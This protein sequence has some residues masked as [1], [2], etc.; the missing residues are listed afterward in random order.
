MPV[1]ASQIRAVLSS[2]PVANCLPS[3]QSHRAILGLGPGDR[4]SE[5]WLKN[6]PPN[7]FK[8]FHHILQDMED[9]IG[10]QRRSLRTWVK[11]QDAFKGSSIEEQENA[12]RAIQNEINGHRDVQIGGLFPIEAMAMVAEHR[13]IVRPPP[14]GGVTRESLAEGSPEGQRFEA[15][16]QRLND[17]GCG[18]GARR[19]SLA[20]IAAL[21]SRFITIDI[22]VLHDMLRHAGLTNASRE[23]F[24]ALKDDEFRA[25]FD[26]RRLETGTKSVSHLIETDGV[27]MCVHLKRRKTPEEKANA[28]GTGRQPPPPKRPCPQDPA[29]APPPPG[30]R[31]VGGDPGRVNMMYAVESLEDGSEKKYVLTR[32]SYYSW[33]GIDQHNARAASWRREVEAEEGV[34]AR[35]IPRTAS[36][37][38]LVAFLDDYASV[39]DPLWANRLRR[40]WGQA[41]FR[42][43]GLKR[44][45]LDRFVQSIRGDS[46]VKPLFAYGAGRFA[47]T[48]RGERAVPTTELEKAFRH[49]LDVIMTDEHL[50][51]QMC[52]AC[53]K[54]LQP[55]AKQSADGTIREVRGLRRCRSTACERVSFKGRDHNAAQNILRCLKEAPRRPQYLSRNQPRPEV[56]PIFWLREQ[57]GAEHLAV[58]L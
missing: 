13:D 40:C 22:R 10:R 19:F 3:G 56:P 8:Y 49:K 36:L 55:V 30:Q 54:R 33:G 57:A 24:C 45:A 47:P 5:D 2:E 46:E 12:V 27:S 23:D 17:M 25:A 51:G 9:P 29:P 48:G 20:P 31:R 41:R 14:D 52:H 18:D 26:L 58:P 32:R 21:G 34:Y 39:Y 37:P 15:H 35:H 11:K 6:H 42:V 53:E 16:L 44:K 50:T 38:Q 1:V 28:K 43:Y 7:V 4:I